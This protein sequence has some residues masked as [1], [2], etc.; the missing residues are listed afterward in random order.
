MWFLGMPSLG[1]P[2]LPFSAR[3]AVALLTLSC[4]ASMGSTECT[5]PGFSITRES[6]VPVLQGSM[7]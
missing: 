1:P 6:L 4:P 7:S 3:A 5:F 2:H